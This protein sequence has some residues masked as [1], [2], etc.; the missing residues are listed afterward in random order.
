MTK[1]PKEAGL[2]VVVR[3]G[4]D[5]YRQ[6]IASCRDPGLGSALGG[7]TGSVLEVAI[8]DGEYWLLSEPGL[9]TVVR[10]DTRPD[11]QRVARFDLLD[12]TTRAVKPEAR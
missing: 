4:R 5:E 8:C 12:G 7:G 9:V 6:T 10:V 11:T 3:I 1:Q 2:V